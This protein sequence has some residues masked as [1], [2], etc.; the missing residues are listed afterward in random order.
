M[1]TFDN[2]FKQFRK[3]LST[4]WMIFRFINSATRVK[5]AIFISLVF[6]LGQIESWTNNKLIYIP[7]IACAGYLF[8]FVNRELLKIRA[9]KYGSEQKFQEMRYT[10]LI[11]ILKT[12]KVYFE[13]NNELSKQRIHCL[14]EIL[15]IKLNKKRI[16]S[17]FYSFVGTAIVVIAK[18]PFKFSTINT[19]L[20][21]ISPESL[22]LWLTLI[23]QLFGLILLFIPIILELLDK[24]HSK[25]EELRDMLFEILLKKI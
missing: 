11:D 21:G 16:S 17:K 9:M 15:N 8:W 24:K 23:I 19:K 20:K 6:I 1:E 22:E 18:S 4:K 5:M 10:Q 13:K 14:I 7:I 3:K 2:V 25:M 12:N